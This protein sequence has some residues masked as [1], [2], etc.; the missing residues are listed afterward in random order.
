MKPDIPTRDVQRNYYC[1]YHI[2]CDF[3]DFNFCLGEKSVEREKQRIRESRSGFMV[4]Y[5]KVYIYIYIYR[6]LK[7]QIHLQS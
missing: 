6:T 1:C 3:Q 5:S 7:F 2:E 4:H